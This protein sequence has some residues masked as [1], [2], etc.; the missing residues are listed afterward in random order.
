ML[1]GVHPNLSCPHSLLTLTHLV[2]TLCLLLLIRA[3]AFGSARLKANFGGG[4]KG[5]VISQEVTQS[6]G[7]GHDLDSGTRLMRHWI[8]MVSECC[9]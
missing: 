7:K 3:G 1:S 9:A 4:G 5:R 8:T 6:K 2:G